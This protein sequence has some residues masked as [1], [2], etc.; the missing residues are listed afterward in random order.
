MSLLMQLIKFKM[1]KRKLKKKRK[2]IL[3]SNM[4]MK[5]NKNKILYMNK[6]N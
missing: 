2:E 4:D 6:K 5:Y 3:L 1:R